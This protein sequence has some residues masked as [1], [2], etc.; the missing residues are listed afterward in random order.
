MSGNRRDG[1]AH[2]DLQNDSCETTPSL[3]IY[4]EYIQFQAGAQGAAGTLL[5]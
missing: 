5:K 1:L 4:A 2:A 3:R